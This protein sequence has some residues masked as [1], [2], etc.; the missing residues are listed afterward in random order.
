MERPPLDRS[1]RRDAQNIP[2]SRHIVVTTP[3][4]CDQNLEGFYAIET[5]WIDAP[6][7]YSIQI[8]I[9]AAIEHSVEAV[10]IFLADMPLVPA[11]HV[12]RLFAAANG[13]SS[14]VASTNGKTP[15]PPALF[16]SNHF[17]ILGGLDGDEG[18]RS[19]IQRAKMIPLA[20]EQLMD[21]DTEEDFKRLKGEMK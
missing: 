9:A 11:E 14:L 10:V 20:P 4:I 7:S 12:M 17:A 15:L 2:F 5:D 18:A 3:A 21:I 13:P 19:L 6:Q 1:F 8:G 16:G